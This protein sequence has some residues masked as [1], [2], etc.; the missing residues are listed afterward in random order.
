MCL[1]SCLSF[2]PTV[3]VGLVS[4]RAEI[5]GRSP[6]MLMRR[7]SSRM[8]CLIVRKKA[9]RYSLVLQFNGQELVITFTI[10]TTKLTYC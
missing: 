10:R 8:I 7:T 9:F 3:A 4:E 1:R 5:A 2:L 6:R